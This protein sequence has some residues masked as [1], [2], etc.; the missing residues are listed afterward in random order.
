[1]SDSVFFSWQSDLDEEVTK[2]VIRKAIQRAI[3]EVNRDVK[4]QESER[5]ELKYDADMM[6]ET[7]NSSVVETICLKIDSAAAFVADVT[8]VAT[9]QPDHRIK[10]LPNANVMIEYGYALK[11]LHYNKREAQ[12]K[13]ILVMNTAFGNPSEIELPFDL[14]HVRWPI[15]FNLPSGSEKEEQQQVIRSLTREIKSSL[16]KLCGPPPKSE[17]SIKFNCTLE[18]RPIIKLR[19]CE[20]IE[21]KMN[22]FKLGAERFFQKYHSPSDGKISVQR[23]SATTTGPD[24]EELRT[25]VLEAT[26]SYLDN[27]NSIW[28]EPGS[29]ANLSQPESSL[30]YLSVRGDLKTLTDVT[31]TITL[32][33]WLIAFRPEMGQ[34]MPKPLEVSTQP[35]NWRIVGGELGRAKTT[36]RGKDISLTFSEIKFEMERL[37]KRRLYDASDHLDS[38]SLLAL[39]DAPLGKRFLDA[40]VIA[41]EL[42]DPIKAQVEINIE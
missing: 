28:L 11:A 29:Y 19:K 8:Y 22:Q 39:P 42:E 37:R 16:H 31:I 40:E 41:E 4:L 10:G 35:G 36:S 27:L 38:F 33:S 9:V 18:N 3:K 2:L 12:K 34:S 26:Q 13:T 15:Q 30:V 1:M 21:P 32:P 25:Q 23:G 14:R 6:G 20:S 5:D 24:T 17:I 7:G